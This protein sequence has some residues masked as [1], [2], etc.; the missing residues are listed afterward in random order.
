[1]TTT[2]PIQDVDRAARRVAARALSSA[3]ADPRAPHAPHGAGAGPLLE[4]TWELLADACSEFGAMPLARGESLP[5]PEDAARLVAWLDA[6]RSTRERVHQQVFGLVMGRDCPP[7]EGEF[8]P[9]KDPTHRA[10]HLAD[11]AGFYRAHGVVPGSELPER[12]DHVSLQL[13][14]VALLH[15]KIE[16]SSGRDDGAEARDVCESSLGSFLADHVVWWVPTFS[17]VLGRRVGR[18]LASAPDVADR[19]ALEALSGVARALAGWTTAE[20]LFEKLSVPEVARPPDPDA[21]PVED[22]DDA[23]SG[24]SGPA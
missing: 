15:E 17:A 11:G 14:F 4:R 21:A 22:E 18:L 24:C 2:A 7:C 5:R 19:A 9:W 10:Q 23:C 8:L 12:P 6:D 16:R 3:L 20:R 13:S 1:M